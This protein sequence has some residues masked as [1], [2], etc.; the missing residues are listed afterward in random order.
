MLQNIRDN[1]QGTIAKIIVGFIIITFALFGIESIVALGNSESAPATVNGTDI[2]EVEILRLVEMQKNRFR[3][4]FGENYDESLFNDSFLRQ[5]ALEQ[6]I[7]QKVAVTQARELGGYVSTQS[8]DKAILASPEFQQDGEFSSDRFKMVLRRSAL[9][10]LAYRAVLEEQALVTQLQLGTGLTDTALPFEVKRQQALKTEQR[11]YEY[12]V[13]NT[14]DLKKEIQLSAEDVQEFYAANSQRYKTEEQ[15]SVDYV[16]LNKSDLHADI[17]VDGEQIDQAYQDYLDQQGETEER[18]ASHILVEIN[19]ERNDDA[20]SALAQQLSVKAISGE[21]FSQLAKEHSDDIGSKNVG[22]EL[23]FNTRGGFVTEFD[24]ALFTMTEGQVSEPVKTE[25][26]YHVIKLEAIRKPDVMS[27]EAKQ[28]DLIAEIKASQINEMFAEQ[29]E[30]LAAAAFE[31]DNIENLIENSDL[32]LKAMNSGLFSRSQ[33]MNIAL[34]PS[35][36]KAAFE[37]KVLADRELSDLIEISADQIV[38]IGLSKHV[39]PTVKPLADVKV[40]IEGQLLTEKANEL[41][42]EKANELVANLAAGDASVTWLQVKAATFSDA[43]DAPAELNKAVFALAKQA[44][45]VA[46]T[47]VANGQAVARLKSIAQVEVA[48]SAE[49]QAAI[50]QAKAN[51]SFYVYREWAKANSDIERSGS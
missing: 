5:S 14:A 50:S 45:E 17:D 2:E 27:K 18:K 20:A 37:E 32:G 49:E 25:F 33:G 16:V 28:V 38:V 6:L 35:I 44:G 43:G 48:V 8:V 23:G 39:E 26:G 24:D 19:D 21:D 40:I 29:S 30:A 10:P 4:Q 41:A 51:E 31:N 7:E 13:F 36:R 34:N 22:G 1:S 3:Q 11:D 42:N 46:S 12:V 47:K 9:T 15:V